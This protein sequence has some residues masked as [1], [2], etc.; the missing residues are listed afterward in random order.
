MYQ[1]FKDYI[2]AKVP[3]TDAEWLEIEAV[4]Q[5]KKLRKHQYLLQEG[6]IWRHHAFVIQGCLKRY[7]IDERGVE[8]IIQFSP[9]NWW[10]GDRQSLLDG[11]PSRFNIDAIEDSVVILI[12]NEDFKKLCATIPAFNTLINNILNRSFNAA[13]QRINDA[14]SLTA[15]E[16]Y[17]SFL[18]K[19]PSLAARIPR[20]MLASYLGITPE[21]LSRIR[22]TA[23]R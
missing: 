16:K 21:T 1:A 7:S 8:H 5:L 11:A 2:V 4:C 20:H 22:K 10:A 6:N 14:I 13:Q 23:A 18:Q 9:E 15:E 12:G 3:I 17:A 19:F